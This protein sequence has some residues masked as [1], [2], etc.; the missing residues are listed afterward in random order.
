M[1]KNLIPNHDWIPWRFRKTPQRFWTMNN[2][3][4][5]RIFLDWLRVQLK[6]TQM[7]DL[8]SLRVQD[9]RENGGA[10]LLNLHESSVASLV[11]KVYREHSWQRW[12]FR[13]SR[14][15]W[16]EPAL[17]R[18]FLDSVAQ[19]LLIPATGETINDPPEEWYYVSK[20]DIVRLGGASLLSKH[21]PLPALLASSYPEWKWQ[22][23]K[24]EQAPKLEF[25]PSSMSDP[26][27]RQ[28]FVSCSFALFPQAQ[29]QIPDLNFML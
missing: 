27:K 10:F 3:K 11:S 6:H 4:N 17:R 9:L 12:R 19:D 1:L 28:Q 18:Q 7:E 20:Q 29:P 2:G 23:W 25:H 16:D 5:Q 8:Y 15:S 21:G 24:F 26:R 14:V 13:F 22:N